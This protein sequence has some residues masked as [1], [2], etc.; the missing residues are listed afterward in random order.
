MRSYGRALSRGTCWSDFVVSTG[1]ISET[2]S[3]FHFELI[4]VIGDQYCPVKSIVN[5]HA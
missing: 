2:G 5:A 4:P 3:T 1:Q